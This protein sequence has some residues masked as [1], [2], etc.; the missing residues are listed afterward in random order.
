MRSLVRLV[1]FAVLAATL[2][3]SA[4]NVCPCVPLSHL[5]TV[6]TCA[7]WTCAATELAVAN[8]DTATFAVPV[9]INDNRWLVVRR[10]PSGTGVIATDD[11]FEIHAFDD[12]PTAS[13]RFLGMPRTAQPM[14]M[15]AP[16][17][18]VL[19]IGLRDTAPKH[20]VTVH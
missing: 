4:Q 13:A 7:D 10:V 3:A 11:P 19:V 5:W 8:G 9:G 18:S 2:P 6:K 20:R 14:L 12:M 15:T 1:M 16:D 17:G